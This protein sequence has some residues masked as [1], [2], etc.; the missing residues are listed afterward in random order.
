MY[1]EYICDYI[2]FSLHVFNGTYILSTMCMIVKNLQFQVPTVLYIYLS[3]FIVNF[4]QKKSCS[5]VENKVIMQY[6]WTC[7]K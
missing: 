2:F 5:V 1:S 3:E 7:V 6:F 4:S